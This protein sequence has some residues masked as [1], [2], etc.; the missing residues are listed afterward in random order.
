MS[1]QAIL[2]IEAE[3]SGLY[4]TLSLKEYLEGTHSLTALV[5]C[6]SF[7]GDS[8]DC[9]FFETISVGS[10][11]VFFHKVH[12]SHRKLLT[13]CKACDSFS[14]DGSG[15]IPQTVYNVDVFI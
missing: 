1:N 4:L 15:S 7:R 2:I 6:C 11:M 3:I 8:D 5:T 10:A 13:F 9:I 12:F 14:R